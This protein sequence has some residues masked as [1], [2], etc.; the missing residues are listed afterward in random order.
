MKIIEITLLFLGSVIGAGFATGAEIITFFGDL[1][2][3][4]W[5]IA[6]IVGITM[7]AIIM[8]EILIYYPKHNQHPQLTTLTK[9][10][11][12]SFLVDI[13]TIIIY[14]VLFTAM[15]AGVTSITNNVITIISLICSVMI[16]LFGF[17]KLSRLNSYIV[18]I[19]ITLIITTA[20]PHLQASNVQSFTFKGLPAGFFWGLLYAGLN[21]FMFPELIKAA[22]TQQ[23]RS[24]LIWSSLFT[25]IIIT[26][27]VGL[28]LS[29]IKNCQ[30]TN[31]TV[32][33]LAAA[34]NGITITIILLAI[35]T[36]QYTALFAIMQ[37]CHKVFTPTKNRPWLTAAGVCVCA[38]IVS[39]FG[40]TQIINF[41]YP[42]IGAI[43]CVS[44]LI[45]WLRILR[46]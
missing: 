12:L 21:C 3:P 7:F 34:P 29:T 45:S 40:F 14:F 15:T 33:L 37:K 16:V 10:S 6:L 1:P 43:T 35:L 9:Q 20:L 26:V 2:L 5:C 30:T 44:L 32:P 46:V 24:T 18:F 25:S 19:I 28:I 17:N 41:T 39:F 23:K 31:A 42:I 13:I 36:T 4:V 27:L 8:L 22:S 38:F 11:R